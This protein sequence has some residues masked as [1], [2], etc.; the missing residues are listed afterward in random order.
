M[1]KAF[2]TVG[3]LAAILAGAAA[4]DD[5]GDKFAQ[6]DANG[7]GV[8]SQEEFTTY[9][10]ASGETSVEDAA[11]QFAVIAGDDSELTSEELTAAMEENGYGETEAEADVEVDAEV[12]AGEIETDYM[13]VESD[14][15]SDY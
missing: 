8:V 9:A 14:T 1:K 7:D 10:T 3:A 15:D 11:L 12:A 5:H 2:I 6:I 13:D 4:A